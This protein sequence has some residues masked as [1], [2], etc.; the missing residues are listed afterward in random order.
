MATHPE[1]TC[2]DCGGPNIV[3][4]TDNPTWNAVM[5]PTDDRPAIL[6]PVCFVKRAEASGVGSRWKLAVA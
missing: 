6:C 4:H 1:D 2:D 5:D 3:W